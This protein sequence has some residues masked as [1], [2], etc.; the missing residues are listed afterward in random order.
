MATTQEVKAAGKGFEDAL[1]AL[2]QDGSYSDNEREAFG[3]LFLMYQ[4]SLA[5]FALSPAYGN[6]SP[7]YDRAHG[8]A[9]RGKDACAAASAGD[10]PSQQ[11]VFDEAHQGSAALKAVTASVPHIAGASSNGQTGDAAA[12]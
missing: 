10:Y 2:S 3:L 6:D 5:A 4:T 11:P 12:A 9:T 7:L 1:Y 8:D